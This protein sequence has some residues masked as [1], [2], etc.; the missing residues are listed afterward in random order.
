M[1]NQN[2]LLVLILA[3]LIVFPFYCQALT[4]DSIATKIQTALTSV[5]AIICIIMVIWGGIM[6]AM[7]N[8]APEKISTARQIILWACVGAVIIASADGLIELVKKWGG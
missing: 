3:S 2:F 6:M 5:G 1:K 7:G 4:L 8:G